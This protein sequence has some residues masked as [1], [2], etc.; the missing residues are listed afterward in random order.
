M[1]ASGGDPSGQASQIPSSHRP[2]RLAVFLLVILAGLLVLRAIVVLV[3]NGDRLSGEK[4]E[5][6]EFHGRYYPVEK[7]C[8]VIDDAGL[9]E[10]LKGHRLDRGEFSLLANGNGFQVSKSG[11]QVSVGCG[12]K[13]WEYDND[14]QV[15]FYFS[16]QIHA[17]RIDETLDCR[18]TEPGRTAETVPLG[19]F[20][21]CRQHDGFEV[22]LIVV[23]DNAAI[24]CQVKANDDAL[25]PA[26]ELA[27][28]PECEGFIDRLAR[29]RPI[30]YLG[31]GFWTVR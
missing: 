12:W 8:L 16:A 31:N 22:S 29:S 19:G 30:T 13:N 15:F 20:T 6:L 28:R 14:P 18:T 3:V 9:E 1:S 5:G 26:L 21:S 17:D 2:I 7:V 11:R 10:G 27:M 24:S 25:L 23:D 4:L